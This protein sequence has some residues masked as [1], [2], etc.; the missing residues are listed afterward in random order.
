L[1]GLTGAIG[2]TNGNGIDLSVSGNTLTVS[3]SGVLSFNGLT[4][5]ISGVNSVN[6]LTGIINLLPST[7]ISISAAG[8]GI[9]FTNIGVVSFN[10]L[11][12]AVSGV[13]TSTA[14]T[15]TALQTFNAGITSAGATFNGNVNVQTTKTLTVD[16]LTSNSG[17]TL[18]I[19]GDRAFTVTTIGDVYSLGNSTTISVNDDNGDVSIG[20]PVSGVNIISS[21]LV[22]TGPLTN[23]GNVVVTYD[24]TDISD[25]GNRLSFS[26][27]GNVITP[28]FVNS[29]GR[30]ESIR[31][32]S[33][34][35]T[36]TLNGQTFTNLVRSFNG[37]TGPV[38]MYFPIT[39]EQETR[40]GITAQSDYSTFNDF[41]LNNFSSSIPNG[42]WLGQNANGGS[43]TISTAHI[44]SYGFDKCNGVIGFITGT[45]NTQLGYAGCLLQAS[46]IPGIPTPSTGFI[47]KYEIECRFM[48]DTDITSQFTKTRI[49]FADTWTN[50]ATTDGVY[51]ER[52]YDGTVNETTFNVVFANGGAEERINTGVTFSAS[53]IYRTYLCV[54]RDTTGA[55]TTTWEILNDTTNATSTGT[56]TP[57]NTARYPSAST[58]Y[59]N[60]GC[61]IQKAGLT[62]TTTSR[63]IRVDY[64][65]T[66]IRR[67]LNRSMKIFS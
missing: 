64:I 20:A 61:L 38:K 13:T 47:T 40:S 42:G 23:N 19:A 59:I 7:G 25:T 36:M 15:F 8:K 37:D 26:D 62:A 6:G 27:T 22:N 10:N 57:S 18:V 66:R 11:T 46:H 43:F 55:F 24:G 53:T 41:V 32:I 31:G 39:N 3:N 34:S 54:E 21:G 63:I 48:T 16:N 2:L 65:G 50:S 30:F 44:T 4:G 9:T 56:A 45:T 1:R 29:V 17:N 58:D 28:T 60:P 12:G 51:F 49:G 33:L 52:T 35:G 14:N 5:A 67:P